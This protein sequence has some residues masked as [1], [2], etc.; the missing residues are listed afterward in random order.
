MAARYGLYAYQEL[1]EDNPKAILGIVDIYA[2]N[3][4]KRSIETD[5]LTY[6]VPMKLFMTMEE[7][8]DESLLVR[9]SWKELSIMKTRFYNYIFEGN[10]ERQGK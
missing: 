4:L 8:A 5:K 10:P 1:Q 2:R 3:N 9:D 6:T 7:D